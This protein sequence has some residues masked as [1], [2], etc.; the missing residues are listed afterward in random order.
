M[1]KIIIIII[2][3]ILF[4]GV[5]TA[6]YKEDSIGL[7]TVLEGANSTIAETGGTAELHLVIKDGTGRIFIDSF[8]IS[9]MDTQITTRF[10]AE[11]ACDFLDIDCLAYDFFYTIRADSALVGGPSAGAAATVLTVTLLDD[12]KLDNTIIM[13]GTINSG[14]LIGPVAGINSKLIAAQN[15]GYAAALIPK[16]DAG[17]LTLENISIKVIKISTLEDALYEFTGKNYSKKDAPLSNNKE[18]DSIMSRMTTKICSRYGLVNKGTVIMPNLSTIIEGY[19]SNTSLNHTDKDYF[20]MA[21][22]AIN[23]GEYYSAASLC[24]G[25]NVRIRQELMKNY[26]NN[27][28]KKEY[29][30][31]QGDLGKFMS[32][33]DE[34]NISTISELETYMVVM[35]RLTDSKNILSV[36]NPEN[37]SSSELAYAIERFNSAEVWAGF[38]E[39]KGKGIFLQQDQLMNACTKKIQEAEERNNYLQ[40]YLPYHTDRSELLQAYKYLED[41]EFALCIFTAAKAKADADVVLSA[42]FVPEDNFDDLL[43]EKQDAARKVIVSQ[44]TKDIMPILGRSYY[45]YSRTLSLTD[46]FSAMVYAEYSLEMSNLDMYFPR[47]KSKTSLIQLLK[48]YLTP[49]VKCLLLGFILGVATLVFIAII[50]L[51]FYSRSKKN[52]ANFKRKSR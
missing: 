17:N 35:E 30:V 42:L 37:I 11:I 8:P 14:N 51:Y 31:L 3:V 23:R 40:L 26:S 5:A 24:F 10:A 46:K 47:V 48:Y 32:G 7:L 43:K 27:L 9:R 1:K 36:Q 2:L 12:K 33:L 41:S 38:F 20:G 49:T 18:Y 29:A 21:I 22:N 25:G 13:T 28:L 44:E 52:K 6:Y 50:S 45:E 15:K 16:W 19:G 4:A 39:F 34:K